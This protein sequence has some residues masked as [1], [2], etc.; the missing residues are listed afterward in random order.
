MRSLKLFVILL[1]FTL[2]LTA[3]EIEFKHVVSIT[4]TTD[5]KILSK[6]LELL[7]S[8]T[9]VLWKSGEYIFDKLLFKDKKNIRFDA[10]GETVIISKDISIE[11]CDN[12]LF[13]DFKH[14]NS[15]K[16]Y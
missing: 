10:E 9:L 3:Q 1:F 14:I 7:P 16:N 4:P 15:K 13:R 5:M 11:N 6:K 8:D 2:S 12:L